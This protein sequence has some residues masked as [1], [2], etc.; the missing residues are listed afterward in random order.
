MHEDGW[1]F[2]RTEKG[3]TGLVPTAYLRMSRESPRGGT[4]VSVITA[5]R[6][7]LLDRCGWFR[8]EGGPLL[9]RVLQLGSKGW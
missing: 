4:E 3:A 1:S 9:W 7:P 5:R 6:H 8:E 2:A